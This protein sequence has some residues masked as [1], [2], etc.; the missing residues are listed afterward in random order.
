MERVRVF[1]NKDGY[2][3]LVTET[4]TGL[5][6]QQV[7]GEF[8]LSSWERI[9]EMKAKGQWWFKCEYDKIVK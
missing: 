4:E 9:D 1:E 3:L 6:V 7:T 2:K 5:K 8:K